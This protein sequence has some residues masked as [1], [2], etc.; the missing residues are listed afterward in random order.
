MRII[1]L[2]GTIA[3]WLGAL[4]GV[5]AGGVWI[6]GQLGYVQPMVV[7]SGSMEPGI[8]TGDLLIS[9]YTPTTAIGV[10]DVVSVPSE[11]TGQLVT[12]RVTSIE[13]LDDDRAE[14]RSIDLA[15]GPRWE[16]RMK[17][18][19]NADGDLEPYF[20]GDEVLT[21]WIQIPQGGKVVSKVMEPAVAMPILLALIALL[22]LSLLD[23]EPR[24]RV[25][26][27]IDRVRPRSTSRRTR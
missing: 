21:P 27:V 16:L 25:R 11:R 20:P 14:Q 4:L 17:G 24:K 6:A 9:R 5:A 10:G 12:H 22:G 3:L 18:D 1:R 23:E 2:L 19:A 13:Q 26:R 8:M 7:I 15:A